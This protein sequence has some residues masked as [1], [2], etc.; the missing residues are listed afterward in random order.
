MVSELSGSYMGYIDFDGVRYWD[1]R[2]MQNFGIIEPPIEKVLPSDWRNR[3]DTRALQA[4]DVEQAQIN[5]DAQENKQRVDRKLREAADKRRKE[6]GA[7][8]DYSQYP[9]HP[10]N[11]Q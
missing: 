2:R 9:N 7:K 10:L 1:I 3:T 11:R 6:G 4:G 5:K 8:I